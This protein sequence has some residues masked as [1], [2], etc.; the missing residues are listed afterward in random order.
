MFLKLKAVTLHK[1][2][3]RVAMKG[4]PYIKVP[5]QLILESMWFFTLTKF[6]LS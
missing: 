1:R 5:W 2:I 4:Q 3:P 6:Y